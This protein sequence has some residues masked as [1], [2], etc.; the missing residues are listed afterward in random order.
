M[1][2]REASLAVVHTWCR[3][4]GSGQG[5]SRVARPWP[6][7]RQATTSL[8]LPLRKLM[9][10]ALTSTEFIPSTALLVDTT[11]RQGRRA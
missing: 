5:T 7:P 10:S 1:P 8:A 11:L 4:C 3:P 2:D 9:P 6:T